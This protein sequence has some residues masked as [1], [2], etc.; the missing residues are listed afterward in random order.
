MPAHSLQDVQNSNAGM[1]C[2]PAHRHGLRALHG[3]SAHKYSLHAGHTAGHASTQTGAANL[4]AVLKLLLP[5]A[6]SRPEIIGLFVVMNAVCLPR[7]LPND[8]RNIVRLQQKTL[9]VGA[10]RTSMHVSNGVRAESAVQDKESC[11]FALIVKET[12]VYAEP[13]LQQTTGTV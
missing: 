1:Y 13:M 5:K 9:Q 10:Y 6:A 12:Q 2:M 11:G 4:L 3:M 8:V 7:S